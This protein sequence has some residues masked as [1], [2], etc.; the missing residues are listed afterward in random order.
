MNK[1]ILS[2]GIVIHTVTTLDLACTGWQWPFAV[3]R[4]DDIAAHFAQKQSEKPQLFNGRVLL[5][6][7]PVFAND[8]FSADYFETD[9]ASFLAW[10]DWGFPDKDVFNGFGMGALRCA[11]G[12]F[13]LGEMGAHTANAGKVYF[14]SGT[15]DP[16]DI[17]GTQLDINASVIREVEEETGLGVDSYSMDARWHC[18]VSGSVIAMMRLLHEEGR[19]EALRSRIEGEIRA[20]QSPELSGI[21][22]VRGMADITPAMPVFVSAFLAEHLSH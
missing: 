10:R 19:G 5:G 20:Q 13:I 16:G 9:F 3:E 1:P 7:N 17:S 14:P 11:D 22:L 4:C 8:T 21:L 15:P 18:V 12:A 2:P 6:R